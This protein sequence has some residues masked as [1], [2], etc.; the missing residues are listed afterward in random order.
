MWLA[1]FVA[2][3]VLGV[4]LGI[5]IAVGVAIILVIRRSS[6]PHIAVLG[7]LPETDIYRN[8][9]RCGTPLPPLTRHSTSAHPRH[10]V[11]QRTTLRALHAHGQAALQ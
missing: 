8:V 2:T 4:E 9:D 3:L 10:T 6:A 11:P 1:A 7:R 5:G